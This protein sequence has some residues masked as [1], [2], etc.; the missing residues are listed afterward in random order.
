MEEALLS[1]YSFPTFSLR[2]LMALSK[3]PGMTKQPHLCSLF[4]LACANS[5]VLQCDSPKEIP[6][7]QARCLPSLLRATE[8]PPNNGSVGLSGWLQE[9]AHCYST[10]VQHSVLECCPSQDP[11]P[12][13]KCHHAPLGRSQSHPAVPPG[14]SSPGLSAP[15]STSWE[16]QLENQNQRNFVPWLLLQQLF[17]GNDFLLWSTG[18]SLLPESTS[19][20]P[21]QVL[22]TPVL[23]AQHGCCILLFHSS[24]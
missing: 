19:R 11:F 15:S 16:M 10:E 1:Q 12:W 4:Q 17:L 5:R 23:R 13:M 21:C 14:N 2:H 8:F 22:E 7:K 6:S 9:R 20:S 24:G 18:A 3:D